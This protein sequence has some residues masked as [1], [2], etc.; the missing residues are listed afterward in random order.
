MCEDK[1]LHF[2]IGRPIWVHSWLSL[3]HHTTTTNLPGPDV[4]EQTMSEMP[5]DD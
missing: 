5:T 3:P 4:Q 1:G 2:T